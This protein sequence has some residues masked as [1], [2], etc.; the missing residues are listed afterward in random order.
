MQTIQ[1]PCWTLKY[2]PY[3]PLVEEFPLLEQANDQS[4][5]VFGHQCPVFTVV[6]NISEEDWA[7]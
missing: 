4:C 3:G 5:K 2:C 1:K 7:A 6:E